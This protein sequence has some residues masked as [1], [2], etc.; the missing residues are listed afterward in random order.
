MITVVHHTV[1]ILVVTLLLSRLW[2]CQLKFHAAYSDLLFI[3][4]MGF[5]F[6]GKAVYSAVWIAAF[7][8]FMELLGFSTQKWVTAG[9]LGTVLL[10]LAGREV[11]LAYLFIETLNNHIFLSQ[12]YPSPPYKPLRILGEFWLVA[13]LSWALNNR[14]NKT[15]C[16]PANWPPGTYGKALAVKNYLRQGSVTYLEGWCQAAFALCF[17][18]GLCSIARVQTI[19]MGKG[20]TMI[21]MI[22]I[23]NSNDHEYWWW[24]WLEL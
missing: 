16:L 5:Q 19:F 15:G 17:R 11:P 21:L 20:V 7:S 6:A 1:P 4:Q 18:G 13:S 14:T 12:I 8:L 24:W 9:G 10:T 22:E 3:V 23:L 2:W